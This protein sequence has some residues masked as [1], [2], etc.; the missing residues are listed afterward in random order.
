MNM[1]FGT[2]V[3]RRTVMIG[4]ALVLSACSITPEPFG[5]AER[6]QAGKENVIGMFANQEKID[7]PI[8]IYEATARALKYNLDKRV[9]LMEEAAAHSESDLAKYALLPQINGSI[10]GA[11]RNNNSA[12]VS[13]TVSTGSVGADST[14]TT[15]AE[16]T[17]TSGQL[18][19]AWD[20]LDFGVSYYGAKQKADTALIAEGRRLKAVQNI[21]HDVRGAFWRASAAQLYSRRL[22]EILARVDGALGKSSAATGQ[23]LSSPLEGLNYQKGLMETKQ[24]LVSAQRRLTL[25]KVELAALMNVRPG[26]KFELELPGEGTPALPSLGTLLPKLEYPY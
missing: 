5:M 1:H 4:G 6:I 16:E 11:H 8:S 7:G 21:V 14:A 17:T 23:L 22:E 9:K 2:S 13:K 3:L 26:S 24:Q 10:E 25:A 20:I 18:E 12:S 15:S 19:F